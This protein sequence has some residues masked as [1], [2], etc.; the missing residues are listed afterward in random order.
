MAV[1]AASIAKCQRTVNRLL[2]LIR[3]LREEAAVHSN[4][5]MAAARE[6]REL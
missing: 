3:P 5:A 1:Y 4:E 6:V 2:P